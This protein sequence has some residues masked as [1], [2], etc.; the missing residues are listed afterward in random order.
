MIGGAGS[1]QFSSALTREKWRAPGYCGG[2]PWRC[3][4]A[5]MAGTRQPLLHPRFSRPCAVPTRSSYGR[6]RQ[7]G[8]KRSCGADSARRAKQVVADCRLML[9][10]MDLIE[11]ARTDP[12]Q[13]VRIEYGPQ[14]RL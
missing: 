6:P 10:E 7:W 1:R 3:G 4:L 8:S 9:Q 12:S 13:L 5:G 11:A 2:V 14:G